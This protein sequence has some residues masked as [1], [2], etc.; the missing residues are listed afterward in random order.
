M[1]RDQSQQ[2]AS[3]DEVVPVVL[4]VYR[5]REKLSHVFGCLKA[6]KIPFLIVY[7]DGPQGERDAREVEAVRSEIRKIDWCRVDLRIRRR[8]IGLGR[9]IRRGI[10]EVLR[11]YG[12]AIVFE[13]DIE[14]VPGTYQYMCDALAHFEGNP[15][16]TSVSGYTFPALLPP[17]HSGV[18]YYSGR[19]SC[20]G[21]GTWRRAWRG[22]SVP[23]WLLVMA[24]VLRGR[25][26]YRYGPDVPRT[27]W[28]DCKRNLWAARFEMLHVWRNGLSVH[29]PLS[30][31]NHM[32]FEDS[33]TSGEVKDQWQVTEFWSL[34]KGGIQWPSVNESSDAKVRHIKVYGHPSSLREELCHQ[35]RSAWWKLVALMRG[36]RRCGAGDQ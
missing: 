6:D 26:V 9:N 15:Q 30:L 5:R 24:A 14:C 2:V 29:P 16:V 13:D 7:S 35:A 36:L 25:D 33:A 32:G 28:S 1:P 18:P 3:S 11:E 19:F 31:T 4:F 22:M 21:W 27:A 10:G 8:N 34:P 12:R 17:G 20:W 23:G